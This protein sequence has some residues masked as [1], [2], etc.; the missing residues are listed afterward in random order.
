MR[1]GESL[2]QT[3]Q[4]RIFRSKCLAQEKVCTLIIDLG[5]HGHLVSTD[6]IIKLGLTIVY[7]PNP[8]KA[9]WVNQVMNVEVSQRAL[10]SFLVGPYHDQAMCDIIPM[11]CGH[12]ILVRPW[13]CAR[14]TIHDG[15]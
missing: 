10:V 9:T 7:H 13:Q 14:R 15:Y 5:A 11:T 3:Q 2:P 6:M 1:K 4:E 12:I 8:H